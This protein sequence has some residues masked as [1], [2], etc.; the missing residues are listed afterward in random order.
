[1]AS[2]EIIDIDKLDLLNHVQTM[3]HDDYRLV[4]ICA[5]KTDRLIILYSFE[6]KQKFTNLRVTID[7]SEEIESIDFLYSYAFLYENEMKDLF[8]VKMKDMKIDFK[9]NLYQTSIK[10]PFN[11]VE[12]EGKADE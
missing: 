11:P 12:K 1:M 6:K 4:Q 9:G 2:Q 8:G 3:K 10:T 5:V 7:S